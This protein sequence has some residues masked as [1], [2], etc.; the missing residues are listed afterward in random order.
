MTPH[1]LRHTAA[2]LAVSAGANVKAVQQ[3]LGH[4]SAAMTLDRYAGLFD[5][6]LDDVAVRMDAQRGHALGTIRGERWGTEP[7]SQGLLGIVR[8]GDPGHG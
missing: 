8:D 6:D 5:S 3:M 1:D 2:S 4:K 7:D